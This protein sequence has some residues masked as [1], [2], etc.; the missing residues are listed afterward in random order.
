MS[1]I[2]TNP[3]TGETASLLEPVDG[4]HTV[5]PDLIQTLLRRAGFRPSGGT[6]G[7]PPT[8]TVTPPHEHTTTRRDHPRKV[9]GL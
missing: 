9:T 4:V 7:A 3:E 1:T 6:V 8:L 5:T 2:W